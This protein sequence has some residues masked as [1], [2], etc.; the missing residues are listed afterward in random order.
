[1]TKTNNVKNKDILQTFKS[2]HMTDNMVDHDISELV[3]I[4]EERTYALGKTIINEDARTRDLYIVHSGKAAITISLPSDL[5]Q[6][7]FVYA[8][9]EGQIFGELSLVDGSRR[10]AT[11]IAETEVITFRFDYN[12]LMELLNEQ[13]R[14]G[15]HLMHNLAIIISARM[16]NANML[17]RNSIMW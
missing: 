10:S 15:Y 2:S 17:W 8:M 12:Q 3:K 9:R 1:M 4:S 14:I 5:E 16:R 13:P 7:E 6:Q 11:V